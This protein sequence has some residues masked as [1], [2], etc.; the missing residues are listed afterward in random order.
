MKK[1]IG[2]IGIVSQ[3]RMTSS[4]L[5]G[6]VLMQ[7][8][9]K[10]LL[11]YHIERLKLSGLE[12]FIAT[13]VNADDDIVCEFATK[14]GLKYYRGSEENVL[15]RYCEAASTFGLD[16]IIRVTSD[17]PLIDPKLILKGLEKYSQLNDPRCYVS[18][19]IDRTYARGFD[20]EIFS[21]ALL[22]EAFTNAT[23]DSEK[24]HVTPYI[25]GNKAGNVKIEH[26]RQ[27]I[28][29]SR[30]RVTVDT[31]EDF[32][33]MRELIEKFSAHTLSYEE[34]EKLLTEHPELV[35]INSMV[36]QKKS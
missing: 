1:D 23:E 6:K 33:L 35:K 10:P 32:E 18:N 2:H 15:S 5:P 9:H 25:W 12:I 11:E 20:F 7:I 22:N 24:E 14:H 19:S 8:N 21:F 29:N 26:I 17:C 27:S 3:V 13:T 31:K 34:I 36:E 28:D 4:R 30:F 16:T